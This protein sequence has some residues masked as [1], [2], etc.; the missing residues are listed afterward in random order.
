MNELLREAQNEVKKVVNF[1]KT[2]QKAFDYM[3]LKCHDISW[4]MYKEMENDFP[5]CHNEIQTNNADY[6]SWF[7]ETEYNF[8]I[9]WCNENN[10]DFQKMY[11]QLGRTSSFYLHDL[12]DDVDDMLYSLL[13]DNAYFWYSDYIYFNNG[14]LS[15]IS[16]E[17]SQEE[18][19]N[20][21]AND[22]YDDCIKSLDDIIQVY[23][24]IKDF[25]ENQVEIFKSFLE[26]YEDSLKEEVERET[27]KFTNDLNKAIE[28][29][30]KYKMSSDDIKSLKMTIY[31]L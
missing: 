16:E 21:L 5:L 3:D 6:F 13:D 24:Y 4:Y 2:N 20:Y 29:V 1:I 25:K 17:E 14:E 7:C 10:Y 23:N 26:N 22:F 9:E 18:V 28:I 19:L 31:T 11:R 8:F 27:E 15:A 30:N 12:G